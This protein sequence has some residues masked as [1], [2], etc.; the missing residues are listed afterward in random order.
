VNVITP[1]VYDAGIAGRKTMKKFIVILITLTS[2]FA[3]KKD[4]ET[5][6][7]VT[8]LPVTFITTTSA[9]SGFKVESA[10]FNTCTAISARGIC[11]SKSPN[12]VVDNTAFTLYGGCSTG[13]GS[14]QMSNLTPNT[15]YYVRAYAV[16]SLDGNAGT[17]YGEEFS[18][19]TSK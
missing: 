10:K 18:Y 4:Q 11:W 16:Y 9:F 7:S 6:P 8:T 2:F 5:Q 1:D 17:A 15:I 12:P 19:T 13:Q 14:M 3:C